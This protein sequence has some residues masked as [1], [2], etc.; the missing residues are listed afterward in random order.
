[1]H[2]TTQLGERRRPTAGFS[3][4]EVVVAAGLLL[5]TIAAV[6]ACVT[7]SGAAK[8]RLQSAM[9]ADRAVR[10]VAERLRSLPFCAATLPAPGSARGSAG[11]DLVAAVFPHAGVA[12]NA[13]AARYIVAAGEEGGAPPGSFI[14]LTEEGGVEVRCVAVFLASEGGAALGAAELDGWSVWEMAEPPSAV[15]LVRVTAASHG[16]ARA[17]SL[18]RSALAA[19]TVGQWRWSISGAPS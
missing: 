1:M 19:P 15:L 12:E 13:E 6:T 11:T 3:L 16:A 2:V 10:V 8:A 18:T 17:V 5:L 14:T 9:D 4:L 7:N